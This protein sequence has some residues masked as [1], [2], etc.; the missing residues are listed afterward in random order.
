MFFHE[1]DKLKRR[2]IMTSIVLMFTGIVLL[3]VPVGYLSFISSALGF[4][5][6][7][8]TVVTVFHFIGSSRI[9]LHYIQ[10][11]I[12]LVIGIIGIALLT[13]DGMFMKLLSWLV[14]TVPIVS[15]VIGIFYAFMYA[16]RS[17]RKSWWVLLLLSAAMML[18]GGFV[19]YN[20]WMDSEPA[21]LQIT[22]GTM[23]ASALLSSIRLIWLWPLKSQ[24][25]AE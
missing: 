6:L 7:V 11:C 5:M 8:A 25:G 12:A 2:V 22:G 19:F 24:G 10:L 18:F 4:T 17:G 1:L 21:L 14:G 9:L 3:L 23:M 20:P 16:R 13:F 15:G